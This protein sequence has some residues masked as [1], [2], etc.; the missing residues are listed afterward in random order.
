[1]G[2][3]TRR[4]TLA[5]IAAIAFGLPA[6]AGSAPD[7]LEGLV[8]VEGGKA[9]IAYVR[10]D[11][12]WTKFKAVVIQALVIPPK[13]RNTA[14]RGTR[15]NFG[16]SYILQDKEISGIQKIY[17]EAFSRAFTENGFRIATEPGPGTLIVASEM[18]NIQLRAPIERTRQ[19]YM[20][21]STYSDG[22]GGMSI[23]AA[24]GDGETGVVI[25]QVA[26][27]YY[28]NEQWER[29][30]RASNTAEARRA[31]GMWGR[32]LAKAIR[33]RAGSVAA[34]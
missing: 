26:D 27:K 15:P 2:Y 31:F 25:A 5:F 19:N 30:N 1:M 6:L 33:Q 4:L 34:R 13:V 16:E 20:A 24:L 17:Y 14:P 8:K 18:L 12:D 23:G 22:F 7:T 10:P 11:T 3:E 9:T 29:N 21:G 32:D 28:P